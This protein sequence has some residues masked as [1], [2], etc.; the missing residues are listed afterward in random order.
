MKGTWRPGHC[1]RRS[2]PTPPKQKGV[3]LNDPRFTISTTIDYF[4]PTPRLRRTKRSRRRGCGLA[5]LHQPVSS[6]KDQGEQEG[7]E[8]AAAKER[9]GIVIAHH[10]SLP[11]FRAGQTAA[12]GPD[13]E[14]ADQEIKR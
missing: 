12:I 4:P 9:N 3:A 2:T 14:I 5:P 6:E 11:G 10:Q 8:Q 7:I 13:Q 1:M